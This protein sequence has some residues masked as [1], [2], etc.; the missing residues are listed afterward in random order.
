MIN[1][2]GIKQNVEDI[3]RYLIIGTEVGFFNWELVEDGAKAVLDYEQE[4]GGTSYVSYKHIFVTKNEVIYSEKGGNEVNNIIMPSNEM[5]YNKIMDY[6]K[7]TQCTYEDTCNV[8][9]YLK[10]ALKNNGIY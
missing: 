4:I 3:K 7:Y 10:T 5:L 2:K 9:N 8:C 6:A 1:I